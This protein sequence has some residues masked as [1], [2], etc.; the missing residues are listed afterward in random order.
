M[1]AQVSVRFK[2]PDIVL[3]GHQAGCQQ[4]TDS[5]SDDRDSHL[6]FSQLVRRPERGRWLV[7]YDHASADP[8]GARSSVKAPGYLPMEIRVKRLWRSTA[9]SWASMSARHLPIFQVGFTVAS[10][11]H[12]PANFTAEFH[13]EP[14][15]RSCSCATARH[16]Y[17]VAPRPGL[18]S[19]YSAIA[20]GGAC[21]PANGTA[22]GA[23]KKE[24]REAS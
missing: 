4:A 1:T 2:H 14:A 21:V 10:E 12:V 17:V 9:D 11:L 15:I 7:D 6:L 3:A 13:G 24:R 20:S 23:V 18:T 16:R 22:V 19:L 8:C 5:C